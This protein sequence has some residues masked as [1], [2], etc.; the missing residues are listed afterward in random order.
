MYIIDVLIQIKQ[1]I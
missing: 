1:Q